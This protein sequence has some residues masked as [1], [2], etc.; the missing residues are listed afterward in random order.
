MIRSVLSSRRDIKAVLT[1]AY[2]VAKRGSIMKRSELK[3]N[4]KTSAAELRELNWPDLDVVNAK[5]FSTYTFWQ[6]TSVDSV[7]KVLGGNCFWVNNIIAMND[8]H[9]TELHK[10]DRQ[11]IFVQCFCNSDNEK[12][13]MWY[14]Y[15]GVYF[16]RKDQSSR[17]IRS[18]FTRKMITFHGKIDH[19]SRRRD[20]PQSLFI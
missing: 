4:Q 8:L 9:E 16:G 3:N 20:H 2:C 11:D 6:Y 5:D 1:N 13:P 12:I 17:S 7:G 19:L 10:D 18:P 14:L 15:G